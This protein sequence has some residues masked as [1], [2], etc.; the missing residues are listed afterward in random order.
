MKTIPPVLITFVL[1]YLAL[2]QNT[3]AVSPEPDG[4]YPGGNTAEGDGA[5]LRLTN[6][7]QN[8]ALGSGALREN[9]T[10]NYNTAAGINA[11]S[12]NVSGVHNT[13]VGI[14]ALLNSKGSHNLALG[15]TAGENLRSGNGNVYIGSGIRG[16]FTEDNTT[17][18]RNVHASPVTGRAVYVDSDNKLGTLSS[19]RRYKEE[20][21]PMDKASE[22]IL[23]LKPVAFRYKKEIDPARMLSFGLIAEEVA[24]INPDLITCDDKGN[25]QTVR[26]DAVNAML[27]NEFLKEH[28][29]VEQ[30]EKKVEALSAGLQKVSAQ[31]EANKPAPR[32]VNNP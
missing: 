11:L 20:I 10:G 32:V 5:L 24:K 2:V 9:T 14:D 30:L 15:A 12:D 19:S 13:A 28:R 3:R 31:L 7:L 29:K 25:P 27:L 26:Y 16:A 4:G 8:A 1:V 23:A 6:G 22:A 17:R 21:K 18:V